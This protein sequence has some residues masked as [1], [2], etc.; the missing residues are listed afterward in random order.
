MGQGE[1]RRRDALANRSAAAEWYACVC[2]CVACAKSSRVD[3]DGMVCKYPSVKAVIPHVQYLVL[4]C[5]AHAIPRCS[6]ST[7]VA[8]AVYYSLSSKL[9]ARAMSRCLRSTR[10][11]HVMY[12]SLSSTR[13]SHAGSRRSLSSKRVA[14]A[15]YYSLSSK[16]VSRAVSRRSLSSTRVARVMSRCLGSTRVPRVM[17]RT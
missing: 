12:H 3:C 8:H 10:V 17:L 11:P 5:V 13:V 16:L 6:S 15:V 2:A 9:V 1:S 7:R 14:H 4:T